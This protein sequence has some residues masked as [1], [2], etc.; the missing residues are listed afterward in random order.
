[1]PQMRLPRVPQSR[2]QLLWAASRCQT[3]GGLLRALWLRAPV[4][5]GGSRR[6]RLWASVS[7]FPWSRLASPRVLPHLLPGVQVFGQLGSCRR[8]HQLPAALHAT[9][10]AAS[11]HTHACTACMSAAWACLQASMAC[12]G[13]LLHWTKGFDLVDGVGSDPVASLQAALA[14]QG[15]RGRIAALLNDGVGVFGAGRYLHSGTAI[16]F[17]LGTGE[18]QP[19]PAQRHCHQAHPRPALLQ[20]LHW[21]RRSRLLHS[22]CPPALLLSLSLSVHA[23]LPSCALFACPPAL[24][25][26]LSACPS[27]GL[28]HTLL[29]SRSPLPT[30]PTSCTACREACC[31]LENDTGA[32]LAHLFCRSLHST[33]PRE[34]QHARPLGARCG[35]ADVGGT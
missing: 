33:A 21:H 10:C 4:A 11:N 29:L 9:T 14:A 26:S 20:Q 32:F 15:W 30:S 18:L 13:T 34:E 27:A 5:T 7:A 16:S 31:Q 22:A 19:L 23:L 2:C 12:R 8:P 1:M 24:S 6:A 3:R 35:S 17:I 25:L 28:L